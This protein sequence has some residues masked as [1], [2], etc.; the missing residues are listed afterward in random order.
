MVFVITTCRAPG[1]TCTAAPWTTV[2][3][4]LLGYVEYVGYPVPGKWGGYGW[5]GFS[6][7]P[8]YGGGAVDG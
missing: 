3:E 1:T 8:G 2:T 4:G 6:G 5:L 7:G